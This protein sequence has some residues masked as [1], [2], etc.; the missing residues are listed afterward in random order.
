[1]QQGVSSTVGTSSEG[2]ARGI[3]KVFR[4]LTVFG[5]P[6]ALDAL[7]PGIERLLADGW[8]RVQESEP[9]LHRSGSQSFFFFACRASAERPAVE[10][11]MCADGPRLSVV[12]I[13]LADGGRPSRAQYNSILIECYLKF[14]Y[15]AA[16]EAG[17]PIELSS[18]ERSFEREYGWEGTRLLKRFSVLANKSIAHPLDQRRWMD[19]LIHLHHHRP[20]RDYG[21][22]LLAKWLSDDGWSVDKTRELIS[23]CEFALDLLSAYDAALG[24]AE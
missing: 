4:E 15:P 19:F 5:G 24:L 16:E 1:V 8:S 14:L 10:L 20:N 12:N 6:G 3:V 13:M 17:L 2:T 18:D 22:A 23:E 7:I 9:G 11:A 21:F